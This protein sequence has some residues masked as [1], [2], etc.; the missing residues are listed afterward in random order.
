MMIGNIIYLEDYHTF[1]SYCYIRIR[2]RRWNRS[3][4][5]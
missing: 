4:F 1:C 2:E 3:T 5:C